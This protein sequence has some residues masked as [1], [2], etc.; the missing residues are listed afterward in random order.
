[1]KKLIQKRGQGKRVLA[2]LLSAAMLC[3]G[4]L[5]MPLT[6]AATDDGGETPLINEDDHQYVPIDRN[7]LKIDPIGDDMAEIVGYYVD[8]EHGP[9]LPE[10]GIIDSRYEGRTIIGFHAGAFM[11]CHDIKG[12]KLP[13]TIR[14]IDRNVFCDCENLTTINIPDS[15]NSIGDGA[16]SNCKSLASI[17]IPDGVTFI[18]E[19]AFTLCSSLT[20][21]TFPKGVT[22]AADNVLSF[23]ESLET[24]NLHSGMK[25]IGSF[26][27]R[28]NPQLKSLTLP[29]SIEEIGDEIVINCTGLESLTL[30]AGWSEIP[31]F[32]FYGCT[33][34]K[35]Y[36]IR[37]G[38]TRVGKYAFYGCPQLKSIN[39]PDSVTS[40][41]ELAFGFMQGIPDWTRA[42]VDG[43]T[44]CGAFGSAAET[45]ATDNDIT[46]VG[47]T[48]FDYKTNDNGTLTITGYHGTE[49][50]VTIPEEING[51]AVTH[52]NEFAFDGAAFTSVVIPDS[53]VSIGA[54]AFQNC[55]SLKTVR[56]PSDMK[57]LEEDR[58]GGQFRDCKALESITLPDTL[59]GIGPFTFDGCE[60]L[61]NINEPAGVNSIGAGAFDNTGWLNSKPD[62]PVYFGSVFC[63]Y[64]GEIPENST[65]TL[66]DGTKHAA[67]GVLSDQRSKNLVSIIL[68]EGMEDI[69]LFSFL[70]CTSLKSIY[71]PGTV[72]GIDNMAVGYYF[73]EEK[74]GF[75]PCTGL[76]I[77]GVTGSEAEKY[78]NENGF[79]FIDPT[80][81]RNESTISAETVETGKNVKLY[82]KA[83]GGNSPYTYAY[84]FKRSSNTKW[85]VIGT[86]FGT[87]ES[88][89]FK[90]TAAADYD[91]KI[92]V[93]DSSGEKA[94]KTFRLTVTA[95]LVNT[96]W[97]NAEKVQ[98][99]DD[100]R[101]TGAAEG[102][103]GDY[104]YAFYFKR[105]VNTKWN[106]IGTEF[107]TK[108]YGITI[109]KVAADY[110]MK[111]IAKDS[112]GNTS[113]KIFT[114]T[115]VESLPLTN[116]SYL[117]AYNVKVGKTVTAAGRFVGGTKPCKYE[118]YFK[119]S[120]NTKWNQLS[121]GNELGTYAKFTPVTAAEYDIK[122]I[123]IDSKGTRASKVMKLTAE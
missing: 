30:P 102:G 97:V 24:I 35:N 54:C 49:T 81:L 66:K 111:V 61:Y 12:L 119:R 18:G 95:P 104:R 16:F 63:S 122:V 110:D 109:P 21:F 48:Q 36:E 115:V 82:A 123:A 91:I 72:T 40:I 11:G 78:A 101:V 45:Y 79:A 4:F 53:I 34:L 75:S 51:T 105:S 39:V 9:F 93:K 60:S 76:T 43:F 103:S 117:N 70:N 38:M 27:F 85:N 29:D 37:D 41:G 55:G 1:M 67:A 73:D 20:S 22:E 86:E 88:A 23:D 90:P 113:E 19:G 5:T 121:Y 107:G 58:S 92:V 68:P 6:A 13:D 57:H 33:S 10:Y 87:A 77:Y 14:Y 2:C 96:S 59:E 15:V 106:K 64:K 99:G 65:L 8:R 112:A 44:L 80:I 98:I 32:L 26:A 47:A 71:I 56:L 62:G 83:A 114:V 69:S 50:D 74:G 42:K 89:A 17:S 28:D 7:F 52:I 120:V 46:F 100:I 31:D 116:I 118:F 3:T 94:E 25:K 84:Y 108:T